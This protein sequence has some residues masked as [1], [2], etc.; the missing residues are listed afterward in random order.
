[1][2]TDLDVI[3]WFWLPITTINALEGLLEFARDRRCRRNP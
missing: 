3:E 1:M 2:K